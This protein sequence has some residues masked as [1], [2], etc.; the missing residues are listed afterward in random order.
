MTFDE[1]R[2]ALPCRVLV[3]GDEGFES[4]ARPWTTTVAQPVA[5]VV[6]A[7][8]ADDVA[9]VVRYAARAGVPVVTQ[10]TGHGAGR[11]GGGGGGPAAAVG[12]GAGAGVS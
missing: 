2:T 7:G 4:A 1:L 3:A 10:P 12:L 5:A 9:S 6:R 8:D 11:G